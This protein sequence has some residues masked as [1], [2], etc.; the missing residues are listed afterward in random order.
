MVWVVVPFK[1]S[2]EPDAPAIF[3][4]P[5]KLPLRLKLEAFPIFRVTPT[6]IV[7]FLHVAVVPEIIGKVPE[8]GKVISVL[9]VGTPPHQLLALFQLVVTPN[10]VPEA[11]VEVITGIEATVVQVPDI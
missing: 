8:L 4:K 5:N 2:N 11:I 10:Q 3:P 9:A 1:V 6:G 7:K